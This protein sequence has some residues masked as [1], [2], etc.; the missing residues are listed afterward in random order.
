MQFSP[1]PSLSSSSRSSSS[2]REIASTTN[3]SPLL[4]NE[5]CSSSA[6]PTGLFDAETGAELKRHPDL[7]FPDGSVI[8]RAEN[9]LFRVHMYQLARRSVCFK[10]MFAV[11]QP[12][13]PHKAGKAKAMENLNCVQSPDASDELLHDI[14][15]CPTLCLQ[16]RADDVANLFAALYDG[17][18]FGNNDHDDFRVVS[19]ILRLSTKYIIESL[20]VQALA[21]LSIAWPDTL[22]VW[23]ARED[24][25]RAYEMETGAH[26]YPSPLAVISL[27]R[28][29]DAPS[30]L[31]SAFYDLSRYSFSQIFE[32][33]EDEPLYHPQSSTYPPTLSNQDIQRLSLGKEASQQAITTLIQAMGQS[34]YFRHP[35]HLATAQMHSRSKSGSLSSSPGI[36]VSAAACR[37]DFSELVDLATQHYLFDREK[38][39]SDPLYVAEELGQLK[40]AEFSECKACARSLENWAARERER[41]WKMVPT[42]FRL[43]PV[44]AGGSSTT[45]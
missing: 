36:C 11:P 41:I 42:W 8:C 5:P 30:L 15:D 19:G 39:C 43:E 27:A 23:D 24:L 33:S 13:S 26:L 32:P 22:K 3:T 20:R 21:H 2:K 44:D 18:K 6:P 16:D 31:P 4:Y 17:P 7:W 37:K 9:L 25:A 14:T 40:S 10:D 1:N 29:V 38:G 35:M 45:S 28:E 12:R 34:Q